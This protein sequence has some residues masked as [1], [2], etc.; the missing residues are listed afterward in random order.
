M[1]GFG[2]PPQSDGMHGVGNPM[3]TKF[4]VLLGMYVFSLV[5]AG[6]ELYLDPGVLKGIA[7]GLTLFILVSLWRGNE[8][9]RQFVMIFAFIGL[10]VSGVA[11]ILLTLASFA[12]PYA[13]LAAALSAYGVIRS[14][15]VLWCLRQQ[16]VQF[17]MY[18]KSMKQDQMA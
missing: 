14:G 9:M 2:A 7:L 13:I 1:T 17:W 4:K 3:P 8:A 15:F 18:N 5:T 16:D 11:L 6:I 12:A 10:C